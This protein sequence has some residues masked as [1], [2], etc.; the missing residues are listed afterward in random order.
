[1]KLSIVIICWND[2][3]VI[4]DCLH[5]IYAGTHSTELEVIVADNASTDG[6]VELIRQN[7]PQVRVLENG[8]NLRFSKANNVGIQASH[9]ELIL[10]LNPDT[11]IHGGALDK[12][13]EFADRHPEAGGFGCRVLNRDGSYQHPA[14]PFPTIWRAWL[15]ALYLRPLAHLS[16]VFISDTYTNWKGDTE[17]QVD[18]QSG[19]CMMFRADLLK[20]LGGFDDRFYYYY[21]DVDLCRRVW[22]AGYP[23]VYTPRVTVT[24]LGGQSTSQRFPI[25]FELDKYR[26]R[27]RYF[28]KYYGRRGVRRCR[29][30]TLAWLRVRQLGY[31]LIQA[32]RPTDAVRNRLELYKVA[33]AWNKSVKPVR[34]VE[35]GEEPE[36]SLKT[37]VQPL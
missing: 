37:A 18:W 9:G 23:I 17:R 21:E 6:S 36:I 29:R 27:Y 7:F 31:G 22:D 33:V 20:R 19:C 4:R 26:N 15:A 24:H 8:A 11:L 35:N 13:V 30:V 2:G 28:Y 25:P 12:W 16:D 3:R 32:L 10:I 34:L 1:M 14:R 5:S